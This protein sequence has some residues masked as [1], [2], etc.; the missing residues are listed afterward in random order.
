MGQD[1]THVLEGLADD[2][3][4][5]GGLPV[6]DALVAKNVHQ[7]L[8]ELVVRRAEAA[9][10]RQRLLG[11]LDVDDADAQSTDKSRHHLEEEDIALS[12]SKA[13]LV[14]V[15]I[16]LPIGRI[17]LDHGLERAAELVLTVIGHGEG[18]RLGSGVGRLGC[19]LLGKECVEVNECLERLAESAAAMSWSS[20]GDE[21]PPS[22]VHR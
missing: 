15:L 17:S 10:V 16:L 21:Q 20:P 2:V 14:L 19:L 4:H 9:V 18:A 1:G 6:V 13:E 8:D 11:L 22:L 7:P 12:G 5:C 3:L